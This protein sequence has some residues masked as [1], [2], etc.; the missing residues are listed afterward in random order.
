MLAA[1]E[2]RPHVTERD[3]DTDPQTHRLPESDQPTAV[4]RV[5]S[6]TTRSGELDQAGGQ[7]GQQDVDDDLSLGDGDVSTTR[8]SDG[9]AASA[10][11]ASTQEDTGG[12]TFDQ[13]ASAGAIGGHAG[14]RMPEG[15]ATGDTIGGT[16]EAAEGR[17][18]NDATTSESAA[19]AS[20]D[21]MDATNTPLSTDDADRGRPAG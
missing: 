20:D 16:V 17:G 21:S 11:A 15:L 1:P 3:Y 4:D 9:D 12:W 7:A 8:V 13:E 5:P 6:G 2:G 19:I 10:Q 18:A 14:T